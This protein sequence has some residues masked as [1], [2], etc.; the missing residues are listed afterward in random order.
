M[1]WRA[2]RFD[3]MPGPQAVQHQPGNGCRQQAE[4]RGAL[5]QLETEAGNRVALTFVQPFDR[6][7]DD[8]DGANLADDNGNADRIPMPRGENSTA[9]FSSS[10]ISTN[11]LATSLVAMMLPACSASCVGLP[12][13]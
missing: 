11:S 9:M 12:I 5:H 3:G 10:I 13:S 2:W 6:S 4:Q 7:G 1:R 8:T